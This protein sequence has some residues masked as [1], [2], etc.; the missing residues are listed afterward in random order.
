MQPEPG[1]MGFEFLFAGVPEAVDYYVEAG[2]VRTANSGS[3][4]STC[5]R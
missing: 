4:S 5:P 1:G 2:A 3:P